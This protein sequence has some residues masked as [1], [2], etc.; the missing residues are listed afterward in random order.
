[1][2]PKVIT[3]LLAVDDTGT[4][5]NYIRKLESVLAAQRHA[6]QAAAQFLD[7]EVPRGPAVYG[8]QNTKDMVA[9]AL[10]ASP[11]GER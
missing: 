2:R 4:V 5:V 9:A 6:L 11:D 7:P 10:A 3:D 1:M 8:W